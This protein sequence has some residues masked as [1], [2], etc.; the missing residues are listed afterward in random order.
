MEEVFVI[1]GEDFEE[2][3][4][5]LTSAK[6]EM[7]D[8][9]REAKEAQTKV[10]P[11]SKSSEPLSSGQLLDF[12]IVINGP[13]LVRNLFNSYLLNSYL[14][15]FLNSYIVLDVLSCL[16][17]NH[18]RSEGWSLHGQVYSTFFCLSSSSIGL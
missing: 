1:D 7:E 14:F 12:A 15:N 17:F 2:V 3:E 13:S 16:V 11:V 4:K 18:P 10:L 9:A 5:Q 6:K 8:K